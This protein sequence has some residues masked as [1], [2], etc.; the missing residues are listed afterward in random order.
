MP[1]GLYECDALAWSDQQA[2]LLRRIAAGERLNEAVDWANVIEE[3]QD[4]GL[5]DLRA[6]E[7]LI[8]QASSHLLKLHAWP[9][10]RASEHWRDEVGT[11]LDD[12]GRRFTPSMRERIDVS[13]LFARALRRARSAR[14]DTGRP[15]LLPEHCPYTLDNLLDRDFDV[16]TLAVTG[17]I[18][19]S[20]A[21]P[22][23]TPAGTLPWCCP[24][25]PPG[26]ARRRAARSRR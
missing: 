8:Q 7:S 21:W 14:D 5:S 2:D 19:P 6:C 25:F 9:D 24:A 10:S 12:A 11:F 20:S 18:Q 3:V 17:W 15:R 1:D 13:E 22:L 16:D 26:T 23:E 4:V